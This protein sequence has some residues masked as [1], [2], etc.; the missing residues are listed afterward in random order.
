LS[1]LLRY[2]QKDQHSN[3]HL[4]TYSKTQ[5]GESNNPAGLDLFSECDICAFEKILID[6]LEQSKANSKTSV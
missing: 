5:T 1:A 6:R 3:A 4:I 2:K